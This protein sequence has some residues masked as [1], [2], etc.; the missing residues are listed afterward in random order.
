M[1]KKKPKLGRRPKPPGEKGEAVNSY[2]SA[3]ALRLMADVGHDG[4]LSNGA[5]IIVEFVERHRDNSLFAEIIPA[6]NPTKQG[7]K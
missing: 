1:A 5:K 6:Q 7:A 3:A 2:Y 4:S